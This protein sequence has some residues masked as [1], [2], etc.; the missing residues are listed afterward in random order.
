MGKIW[1][2]CLGDVEM[3]KSAQVDVS[4]RSYIGVLVSCD[5]DELRLREGESLHS[6]W[7]AGVLCPIL[8]DFHHV[9]PGLIL[10]ERLEY[11]HLGLQ[12]KARVEKRKKHF[13]KCGETIK[14]LHYTLRCRLCKHV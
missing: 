6:S 11:H 9:E 4:G 5:G 2:P 8:A 7:L 13:Q 12:L 3:V 1:T 14:A 10:V